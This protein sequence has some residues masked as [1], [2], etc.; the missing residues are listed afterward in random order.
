MNWGKG[1]TI[2]MTLFMGFIVY[3]VVILMSHKVDLESEDYYVREIA[4]EDEIS[5]LNSGAK[6]Q[7]IKVTQDD[8][9]L[10]LQIPETGVYNDVLIELKRPN[11]NKLDRTYP[12][13]GT[14]TFM[15]AKSELTKGQY[16]IEI[17]YRDGSEN[18]LQKDKIY[19]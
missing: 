15:I 3:L 18:C 16:N 13:K 8:N 17:S 5:A 2:A 7:Q 1:I 14:K 9:Y 19:I 11:D 6:N 10:V 12:L 4:Y